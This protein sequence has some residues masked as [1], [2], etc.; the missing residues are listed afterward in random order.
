MTVA[1]PGYG[2]APP[3]TTGGRVFCVLFGLIGLPLFVIGAYSVGDHVLY[4]L[5]KLRTKIYER[6]LRRQAPSRRLVKY[7]SS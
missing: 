5:H 6:L 2:N 4:G 1:I 3:V 7:T